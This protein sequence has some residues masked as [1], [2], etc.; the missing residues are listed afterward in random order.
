M[1]RGKSLYSSEYKECEEDFYSTAGEQQYKR[2]KA[3]Q[4][5]EIPDR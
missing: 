1:Q 3:Q 5:R 4:G 2:A